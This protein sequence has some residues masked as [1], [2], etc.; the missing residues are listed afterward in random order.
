LK[1]SLGVDDDRT[2]RDVNK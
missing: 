1:A 2:T